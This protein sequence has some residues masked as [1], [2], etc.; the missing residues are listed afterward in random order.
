MAKFPEAAGRMF[1]NVFV[2]KKCKS[3]IRSDPL[4]IIKKEVTCRRCGAKV[5]RAIR[6]IKVAK[7]A[8]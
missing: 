7:Q 1:K 4:K 8:K 3:K 5:F 2:C 6:K